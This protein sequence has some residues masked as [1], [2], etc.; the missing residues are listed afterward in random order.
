M[1]TQ[2]ERAFRS[3][4]SSLGLRPDFHQVEHRVDAHMFISVLAYHIL[5][6]IEFM[7]RQKGDH[8]SWATIRDILSTHQ[9]LTIE[10]DVKEQGQVHRHHLRLCSVAEPEHKQIYE[11]L[12]LKEVPLLRKIHVVK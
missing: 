6:S 2:I 3:M 9:R 11:R 7:L 4:K 12:G 10:Y 1:H 5:H 8:R